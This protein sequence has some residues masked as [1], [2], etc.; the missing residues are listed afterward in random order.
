MLQSRSNLM[1][2]RRLQSVAGPWKLCEWSGT[3]VVDTVVALSAASKRVGPCPLA[4]LSC[5]LCC[6]RLSGQP[7][8]KRQE[9]DRATL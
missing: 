2:A 7:T 4:V 1:L 8:T 9:G 5:P 3:S 6:G